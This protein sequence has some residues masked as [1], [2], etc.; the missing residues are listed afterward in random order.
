MGSIQLGLHYVIGKINSNSINTGSL[1][2]K[3]D[4]LI[5]HF[6]ELETVGFPKSGSKITPAHNYKE[7]QFQSF[8]PVA[9]DNFRRIYDI[10]P[11][12]YL[13]SLCS[14][15]MTELSNSGASGSIFYKTK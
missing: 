3:T 8:A 4:V 1:K 6:T 5:K 14:C 12:L 2:R 13:S 11:K 10:D 7:F 15:P 9:F